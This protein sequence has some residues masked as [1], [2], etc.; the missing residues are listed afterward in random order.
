MD[1]RGTRRPIGRWVLAACLLGAGGVF[2]AVGLAEGTRTAWSLWNVPLMPVAFG[3][4]RCITAAAEAV[5]AGL[6][7]LVENPTDLRG[8]PLNYPRLWHGLF[9][10]G[11]GPEH[12]TGLASG[13]VLLFLVGLFVFP[14]PIDAT[15]GLVLAAGALSPAVVLAMERGNSE[16]AVWALA[17]FAVPVPAVVAGLLLFLAFALKL[18]PAFGFAFLLGERRHRLSLTLVFGTAC[19][20]YLVW[21]H[22]DGELLRAATPQATDGAFGRALVADKLGEELGL[23]TAGSALR[24]LGIGVLAGAWLVGG[25]LRCRRVLCAGPAEGRTRRAF[26]IGAPVFAGVFPLAISFDYRLVFLL[27]AAP[28]LVAW[29][30]G[31]AGPVR[32]LARLALI[33]TVV[34]WWSPWWVWSDPPPFG[35]RDGSAGA[36]LAFAVDELANWTCAVTVT[37]LV[38]ACVPGRSRSAS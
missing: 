6:D 29:A 11:L 18:F 10:L 24:V 22:A 4:A 31:E 19:L 3:D 7:P 32:A 12:T 16:L 35:A 23:A 34:S 33:A 13:F 14:G 28:Q 20:A 1:V 25:C 8:R 21:I 36:A 17:A 27:L 37:L 5:E 26:L 30:R 15:T 2:A 9:A 38:V